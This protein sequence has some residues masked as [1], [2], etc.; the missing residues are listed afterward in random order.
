MT[1]SLH[2]PK[3]ASLLDKLFA[4]ADRDDERSAGFDRAVWASGSAQQMADAAATIY[5]PVSRAGAQLLYLLVRATRPTTIVEY[6]TSYAIS[7]LHLAAAARDNGVGHVYG[8]ELSAEKFAAAQ[9]NLA[10]AGLSDLVTVLPGD[11]RE[12]LSTIEGPV[13]FLLVDGWKDLSI[14]VLK[15]LE[16]KLS[17]GALVIADDSHFSSMADYLAYVRDPANGYATAA[18][19]VED[20]MEISCRV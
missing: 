2:D 11:A 20:G 7:T 5:M 13:D 15:L 14:P 4:E 3:I 1:N 8:T 12:T 10:E 6:G 19:P 18:F 17:P 16:P 9:A